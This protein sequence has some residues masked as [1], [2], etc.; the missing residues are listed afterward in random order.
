MYRQHLHWRK[1]A[2][3]LCAAS[4]TMQLHNQKPVK[5]AKF[6]LPHIEHLCTGKLDTAPGTFN[7]KRKMATEVQALTS[8][9][10]HALPIPINFPSWQIN[11]TARLEPAQAFQSPAFPSCSQE[12]GCKSES[13]PQLPKPRLTRHLGR[14]AVRPPVQR[15]RPHSIGAKTGGE[16]PLFGS[17]QDP[18][19]CKLLCSSH[20]TF[21]IENMCIIN[22]NLLK[23]YSPWKPLLRTM[24]KYTLFLHAGLCFRIWCVH[25]KLDLEN[26]GRVWMQLLTLPS[27]T[28]TQF[29]H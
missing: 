7:R 12:S 9:A 24:P 8:L 3:F 26:L 6:R 2:C 16:S 14:L 20:F 29:L 13:H 4:R 1:Q 10:L 19:Q 17:V 15:H 11:R 28:P 27:P 22:K 23:E 18:I 25:R 5:L 21:V